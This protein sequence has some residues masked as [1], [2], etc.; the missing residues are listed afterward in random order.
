MTLAT[1]KTLLLGAALLGLGAC[2]KL[3][4]PGT[5]NSSTTTTTTTA[6]SNT[7]AADNAAGKKLNDYIAAQNVF[8]GTFGFAEK[9]AYYRNS[10]IA[11][12]S[13]N[14]IFIVDDGSI[15]QG[16][17]KLKTARAM[18]GGSPDLDAAADAL[19]ASM[20]KAQAHLQS[21]GTYYESKK[22]LDDKLAR[23]K[24]ENAQ[25][26]AELDAADSDFKKFG[27]LLDTEIDKRDDATLNEMKASGDLLHYNSK[28]A[29]IHAKRLVDL[30]DGPDDAKNSALIAKGDGEVAII[31]KALADAHQAATSKGKSDPT[32]LSEL[33]S[34][35]GEYRT[36]KQDHDASDLK[37]MVN[38]YNMAVETSNMIGGLE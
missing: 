18:S 33:T 31:E 36:F 3:G 23:G 19:I 4:M 6:T 22:Y 9:A 7:S 25:M 30:F 38:D 10:D 26:L 12:A 11:H 13:T 17:T 16:V 28:L 21:L 37:S 1:T 5:G 32:G 27:A 15:G 14:G 8:V 34:M 2:N 24:A 35:V 20:G 29:L